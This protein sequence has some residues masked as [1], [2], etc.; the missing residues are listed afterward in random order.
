MVMS[1]AE[2]LSANLEVKA[3]HLTGG[4]IPEFETAAV[5]L[6]DG[7]ITNCQLVPTGSNYVYLLSVSHNGEYAK[8]I[9][10]PRRGE[11][12]LWDFSDG[13]LYKREYAA[14]L[15]SQAL[16][17]PFIPPT[18][19]RD[20][21]YGIGMLQWFINAGQMA[22][23]PLR[24]ENHVAEFKRIVVFDWLVNNADRKAGHCLQDKEGGIWLIDHGLTFNAE[25]KL[26]TVIWEF[27]GHQVPRNLLDDLESLSFQL[28][29]N[30]DLKEALGKLLSPV[31]T[32]ALKSRLELILNHPVFPYRFGSDRRVP[33]PP[34]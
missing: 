33:W 2:F 32:G 8:A 27:A 34:F 24:I 21:P 26:R 5:F 18:V 25:P 13:T 15:V 29:N 12:P 14:Y 23:Y 1:G 10:K 31:E 20:G 28:D 4:K 9:Y 17:W 11:I 7:E 22:V 19:I 3:G 16:K 6:R 30:R